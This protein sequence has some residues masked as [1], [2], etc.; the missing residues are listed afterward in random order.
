VTRWRIGIGLVLLALFG[1]LLLLPLALVADPD[2][3]GVWA[4]GDRLLALAGNT[5][6][7]V[8]GVLLLALPLGT[9]AAVLLYRTDLPLRRALRVVVVLALFVPLPLFTSGW[10]AVLG[11]GGLAP[12]PLWDV[13]R[14][15]RRPW[16]P[17]GQG[18]G[19]AVWVQAVAALPWVVLL[20]GQGLC[21]VERDL[22]E[23]ALTWAGPLR[24]LW[25]VTLP[26]SA[27]ALAA[28]ALW[29]ALQT[30]GEVTVTDV[31]QVRTFAEEVYTQL[32]ARDDVGRALAAC[33][34]VAVAAAL[35]M[36]WLVRHWERR[37]P[38]FATLSRPPLRFGLGRLRWPLALLLA[39]ACLALLGLPLAGLVRR[40]GQ[41][42]S[43]PSWSAATVAE[44]MGV[45]ARVEGR[46]IVGNLGVA[47]LAGG[48]AAVLALLTC[49]AAL[50]SR[51][52]RGGV[53]VLM[54]FAWAL[55]GPVV[56]LGLK[57]GI[58]RLLRWT[59][60]PPLL[61]RLLYHGPSPLPLLWADLV[62][63][64][65]CAV[66]LLWPVVRLLPRE[67]REAA[68]MDGATPGQELRRVVWPL[69]RA[70]L[71]RTGLAVAVLSLGELAAGKLVSTPGL[72]GWAET[73]FTQMHYGV[74]PDLAA[75][76]LLLLAA[77]AAG[78]G[79]IAAAGGGWRDS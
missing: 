31:M 62:R 8:G 15:D 44:H 59:G 28:A 64:F 9:A 32:V 1:P 48:A 68:W 39:A 25:R 30:A 29:V 20:A 53:P 71:W 33:L 66:A 18:I 75:R 5:A 50:D 58:D 70:A 56:G 77:S 26:R 45:L 35:L 6:L 52:F 41:T 67:L 36:A 72:P 69:P 22:E 16:V 76:C 73:V 61:A 11:G 19:S 24:V 40:A 79:V 3:W 47:G 34:P 23:E 42:G 14:P 60:S 27:A 49:W 74:T 4:E 54:A 10:Q 38:P 21:W 17:W 46:Q 13:A 37:L 65:P 57:E 7:L 63:F 51:R 55:P 78:A 2:A 12:L 43:P